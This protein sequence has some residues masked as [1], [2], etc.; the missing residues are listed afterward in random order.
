[1]LIDF[2]GQTTGPVHPADADALRG[3]DHTFELDHP[4]PAFIGHPDAPV[5]ILLANGGPARS[6][7]FDEPS[8][9]ESF[10]AALR[11]GDFRLPEHHGPQRV[12]TWVEQKLA[13]R[14]NS[15][16]YRSMRL[17]A[18]PHNRKVAET[19][20]SVAVHR[21]WLRQVVLPAAARDEKLVIVHRSGLWGLKRGQDDTPN[22]IFTTNPISPH[23][24]RAALDVAE[25]WLKRRGR[26]GA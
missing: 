24:S 25:A 14:V 13:V 20:P 19:L 15:V 8:A 11:T 21:R 22:V 5:I 1:M 16:A 18:E 7:E 9:A 10:Y 2:W 12:H 6:G 26:S 23:P 3:V 17:S 4:P